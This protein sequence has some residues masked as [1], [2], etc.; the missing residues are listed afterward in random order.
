M[1][2]GGHPWIKLQHEQLHKKP[3]GSPVYIQKKQN[4]YLGQ[5]SIITFKIS[6]ALVEL[7]LDIRTT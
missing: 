3:A 6:I 4:K 7:I 1:L 2:A 5:K